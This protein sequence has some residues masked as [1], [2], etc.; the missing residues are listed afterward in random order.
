MDTLQACN[1]SCTRT[2]GSETEQ[3]TDITLGFEPASL[4]LLFGG[5]GSGRNLLLRLLGLFERPDS[6]EIFVGG[7]PTSNWPDAEC[8]DIRS[9]HFG[10]VFEAPLLLP[11]F[12]VA[13][14][15]AMP[16][17]KLT[18]A[19]PA[20]AREET[21][22]VLSHV[23]MADYGESSIAELPLWAQQRVALARALV[24]HPQAIFVE[25]L[26]CLA[27]DGDLISL[28]DLLSATRRILGC[29]I[30]ATAAS[31]DLIHFVQRAVEMAEG[32]IVRD[33]L[34]GGPNV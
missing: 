12:N 11:S 18:E 6:G 7:K 23:G 32:R 1:V 21:Q 27:R 8:I 19:T 4:N 30:I 3:I 25:N 34:P 33:W 14:N 24:T 9:Q 31:R 22:R 29:C 20:H 13:E 16:L 15:I 10:F 28:L 2:T 5:H 26:D 17:F